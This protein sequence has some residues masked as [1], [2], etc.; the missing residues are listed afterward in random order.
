MTVFLTAAQH[1]SSSVTTVKI[2]MRYAFSNLF[3]ICFTKH[4]FHILKLA[5]LVRHHSL[6][7]TNILLH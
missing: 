3:I 6:T 1:L 4:A 7:E 5:V 2:E